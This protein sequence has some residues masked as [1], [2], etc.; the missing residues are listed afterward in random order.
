MKNIPRYNQGF[1]KFGLLEQCKDGELCKAS[2]VESCINSLVNDIEL[3]K[4]SARKKALHSIG[5][6]VAERMIANYEDHIS[7]A[8][9]EIERSHKEID[10]KNKVIGII[11]LAQVLE[12]IYVLSTL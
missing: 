12:I 6:K 3:L 2:D 9:K 4:E 8:E 10:W 7:R 11:F 5:V 1:G